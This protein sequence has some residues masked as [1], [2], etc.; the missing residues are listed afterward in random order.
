MSGDYNESSGSLT[1]GAA[2]QNERLVQAI[3][4][5]DHEAEQ[6]FAARFLRPVRAMLMARSRNPDL[7]ADHAQDVMIEAICSL[8]RGQLREAAK[9]PGF[10]IA[11]A[12]NRLNSYYRS[13]R[14]TEA[15]ELPD[16]LP[17]LSSASHQLEDQQRSTQAMAAIESLDPLDRKILQMTLVDGLK[18]GIIAAR[19]QLSPD[20]V[21]QRKLRATRRVTEFVR[22]QSQTGSADHIIVG[23]VT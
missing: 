2:Q 17:D 22:V 15:L 6:A 13:S 9:L 23:R 8:R 7:T 11:I 12:R 3:G 18:P 19:L 5:G 14:R 21:R 20:V 1:D 10:V 16:D 4:E